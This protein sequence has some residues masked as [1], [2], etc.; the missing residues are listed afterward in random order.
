MRLSYIFPRGKVV[1][2]MT[3]DADNKK[4]AITPP[5]FRRKAYEVQTNRRE[6][7]SL[8][9]GRRDINIGTLKTIRSIIG[10]AIPFHLAH[11]SGIPVIYQTEAAD[12]GATCLAIVLE[13]HKV[14][15][16]MNSVRT[17]LSTGQNGV[18]ARTVLEMARRYGVAGRGVRVSMDAIGRL[19]A[20]SI[21]FWNFNHF[22]V[23]ERATPAYLYIVD[24]AFGRR[25]LSVEAAAE[26]FTGVALEFEEPISTGKRGKAE[27]A[28]GFARSPW[29]L[30]KFFI[31]RDENLFSFLLA[32]L[33][34][35]PFN[36]SIPL[37]PPTWSR[38]R[39]H[40]REI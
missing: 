17:H 39:C 22:V 19:R 16:D 13:Y 2:L 4:G 32:S 27:V 30:L 20:G 25:R 33:V 36:L 28:G 12:C 26:C 3:N 23:F 9:N 31:R 37:F 7:G 38:M 15:Y 11:R 18:S 24:P 6:L 34:L 29:R 10:A 1:N 35:I 5:L 40:R 14:E 21:L 8:L